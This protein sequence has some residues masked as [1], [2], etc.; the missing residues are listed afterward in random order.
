MFTKAPQ[1]A[2][3]LAAALQA[4]NAVAIPDPTAAPAPVEAR[5]PIT[6]PAPVVFVGGRSY[7]LDKRNLLDDIKNGVDSIA[8]SWGSVLGTD[9]PSYFTEGIPNFFQDLPTGSQVLSSLGISDDDLKASPTEV[10]NVP[11]YANWTDK[12]WNVRFHG[13]VYKMPNIS[14]SKIDDLANVFLIDV[15]LKDLPQ[16]QQDQARNLTKEIF[17]V[18]QSNQNVSLHL[19]PARSQGGD[20][21]PGGSNAITPPGGSQN[22]TLPYETTSEGDF[23]VFVPIRNIS[24]GGLLAGNETNNVQ[25]LNVYANGT[26]TGNATAYLVPTE[27]ITFISDIDDILRVTKIYDPKEGLLN[28][29]ARPFTQWMNMPEIY[30][31]WS[32]SLPNSTHFHYL[33][34]TPEQITRNYMDFIFKTYPGGSFDT[35]PLNFSDVSATL[36]IRKYLLDKVFETFPKRKFVLIADTSN[37]D[38][39]KDYPQLAHDHPDQVQCIFLRNTSSTDDSDWFPYDTS[40][41]EGLN[42][43]SYMFFHVPDDLRGLDIAN[44]Q[45][46]NSTIQQNVTFSRQDEVLGIHGAGVSLTGSATMSLVVALFATIFM[47]L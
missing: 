16:S 11:P 1:H 36:S 5:A 37:S 35:R 40:G 17:I 41:F 43:K 19:E 6:T 22:I 23:D 10:L 25:R 45:C 20:G 9:L 46:L 21:E 39:M 42:N 13:N 27:G 7:V 2:M 34:T 44:G 8:A 14:Q 12:G 31:N 47:V 29:F 32:Q 24:G 18:Q 15:K 30:A 38:V 26:L 4:A 28:S 3:L 33:T